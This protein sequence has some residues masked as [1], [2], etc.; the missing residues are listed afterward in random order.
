MLF[1]I[2]FLLAV[3]SEIAFLPCYLFAGF[4]KGG[5][6]PLIAK[7][8]CSVLFILIGVFAMIASSNY[9]LYAGLMLIGLAFSL[10]GDYF[11]S[12]SD[13]T[14]D[15]ITGV[16][17]FLSA[18]VFYIY[19]YS[20]VIS[21]KT[22]GS[23]FNAYEAF[24]VVALLIALYLVQK[25]LELDFGDIKIPIFVYAAVIMTML[26]KAVS[27]SMRLLL[28]DGVQHA[29]EIAALLG[30]GAFLFVFS[31]AV[32]SLIMFGGKK[33]KKMQVLNL[34]TYYYGQMLLACS[35][36]LIKI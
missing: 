10:G 18:H 7:C 30:A 15:F 33:T 34:F 25:K 32:L 17:C 12:V 26:V 36:F 35:L 5:K 11:L 29:A 22:G 23:F 3:V 27:L 28:A 16:A 21:A 20:K 8:I 24:S 4:C 6:R 13:T 14:K 31:D 1:K 9:S 19:A 2:L